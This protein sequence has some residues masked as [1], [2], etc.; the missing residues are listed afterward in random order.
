MCIMSTAAGFVFG[1]C[2]RVAQVDPVVAA[3]AQSQPPPLSPTAVNLPSAAIQAAAPADAAARAVWQPALT[4]AGANVLAES[5]ESLYPIFLLR[6]IGNTEKAALWSR[7]RG[8]WVHWT[9]KL[10]K[11]TRDGGVFKM[12]PATTTFDVSVKFDADGRRKLGGYRPNTTV[13]FVGRLDNFDDVFRTFSLDH[14]NVG[15]PP[16]Q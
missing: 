2:T 1:A 15:P 3:D 14:G 7:Y 13:T 10:I 12:L 4:D 11:V 6:K 5:F 16:P 8:Q 9:G